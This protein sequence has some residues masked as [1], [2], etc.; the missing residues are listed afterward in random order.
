MTREKNQNIDILQ[1]QCIEKGILKNLF[2]SFT[3]ICRTRKE[4]TVKE[5]Y[6]F[7][8]VEDSYKCFFLLMIFKI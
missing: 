3:L 6:F 4:I 7:V 1:T 5:P 8:F 2:L